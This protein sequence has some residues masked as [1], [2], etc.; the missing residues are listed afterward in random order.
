MHEGKTLTNKKINTLLID[1]HIT[2]GYITEED[3]EKCE[4]FILSCGYKTIKKTT[5]YRY[6]KV[7]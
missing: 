2:D 6:Y 4:K 3:A 7:I 1:Y 5:G